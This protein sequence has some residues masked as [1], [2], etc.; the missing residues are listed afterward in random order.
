M[1]T[2]LQSGLR[3]VLV[4]LAMLGAAA[5]GEPIE[6]VVA[7]VCT[8]GGPSTCDG[9][10]KVVKCTEDGRGWAVTKVCAY[11]EY[12]LEGACADSPTP[13]YGTKDVGS[14]PDVAD[15]AGP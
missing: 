9:A 13:P 6:T 3:P 14:G 10:T 11:D 1:R 4:A 12:C 8:P 5:C 7:R 2:R 15:D